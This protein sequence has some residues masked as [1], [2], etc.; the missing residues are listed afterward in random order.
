MHQQ[1]LDQV[2]KIHMGRKRRRETPFYG[3][4]ICQAKGKGDE[5]PCTNKA[6]YQQG[7]LFCCGVH[8]TKKHRQKLTV[9]PEKEKKRREELKKWK[10]DVEEAAQSR[11][12]VGQKGSVQV[13]KL[14]MMKPPPHLPGYLKVFPNHRHA[15]RVDGFGCHTLSPMMLGPVVHSMRKWPTAKNLENFHQ[16]AKCFPWEVEER[17]SSEINFSSAKGSPLFSEYKIKPEA[18]ALRK[19]MYEDATPY[20]HKYKYPKMKKLT[21]GKKGNNNINQPLFS[22][23]YHQRTGEER[24]YTYLQSRY[25]YCHYY[26]TLTLVN[27]QLEQLQKKIQQGV[28]LHILGYDGRKLKRLSATKESIQDCLYR[29]YLDDSKP[30]GHELVLCSLLAIH[31]SEDY[32]WNRF[33]RENPGLYQGYVGMLP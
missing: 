25:F 32:P 16:G 10:A 30:F 12:M 5:T 20:R 17:S 31:F 21:G 28:S 13:G 22:A 1:S 6:Y 14:R 4:I 3:Q 8:S 27:S 18:T 23:Y 2:V 33:R 26:E 15:N 11:R 9:D 19:T 24:R 29:Y 7:V